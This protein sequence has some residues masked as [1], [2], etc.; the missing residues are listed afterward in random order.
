MTAECRDTYVTTCEPANPPQPLPDCEDGWEFT[1]HGTAVC[2]TQAPAD[3]PPTGGDVPAEGIV[4]AAVLLAI[5]AVL[6]TRRR[7]T[8]G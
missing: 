3:L 8:R 2:A 7:W 6:I 5:G 4:A 1:P